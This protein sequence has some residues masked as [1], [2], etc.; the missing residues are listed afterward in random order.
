LTYA[1]IRRI[2]NYTEGKPKPQSVTQ[3]PDAPAVRNFGRT[4]GRYSWMG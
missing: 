2:K 3:N 1:D 4:K